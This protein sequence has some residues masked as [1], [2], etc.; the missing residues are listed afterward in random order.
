ME[1]IYKQF[2]VEIKS[3]QDDTQSD[4]LIVDSYIS[5]Y[6]IDL[7]KDIILPGAFT[8]SIKSKMD[9]KKNLP[10]LWQ[11]DQSKLL[12]HAIDITENE[13]GILVKTKLP[14]SHWRVKQEIIPLLQNGSLTDMSIGFGLKQGD[15][16][17]N[18]ET[19]IRTI[20]K[21]NIFEY[22]FVSIGMNPNATIESFKSILGDI[23]SLSDVEQLLKKLTGCSNND[24][25]TLISKVKEFS[26][27]RDEINE[28]VQREAEQPI[29]YAFVK[30][31]IDTKILMK[32]I[33]NLCQEQNNKM[34]L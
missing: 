17:Y 28:K 21:A 29:D 15:F 26:K 27:P 8:E 7:G 30:E 2:P 22:S 1:Q 25:K 6:G 12:G 33:Q 18:E 32:K 16:E 10:A 5:T 3:T 20:K 13:K 14:K 34:K 11:H 9:K 31:A 19:N 24:V 4:A 23:K